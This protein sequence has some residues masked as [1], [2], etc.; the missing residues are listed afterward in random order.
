MGIRV[1]IVSPEAVPFAKT[2]GLA[3]VA[4]SLPKALKR[5]G[6]DV[7][8]AMPLYRQVVEGGFD[9]EATDVEIT[10]N[11]G[12]HKIKVP[13]FVGSVDGITVYFV[14]QDEYFDRRYLYGTPDGDYFD[15]LERFTLFSRGL[16][17]ILSKLR[18]HYDIIHCNDWQTGLIPAYLRSIFK[19]D[20]TFKKTASIF[21][22]HNIA[23][24]GVFPATSFDITGLPKDM[25]KVEG[26]E[27]WN[28]INLLKSGIV[29][30]DLITTVSERYSKEIQTEEFGYGLEGIL[31]KRRA[32]LYGVL[33][34]VDY[35][36]WNPEKDKFIAARYT[37]EDLSGKKI[38]KKGLIAEF[39]LRLSIEKP[40]IA[41]ISR[42]AD[43]K[44]FDILSRGIDRI[45]KMDVGMVVLGTGERRYHQI[46]NDLARKYPG[47]LGVKIAY[48]NALAHKIEAGADIFLMPS[49]YEPCGLNQ[50][51]SLRY[52]TVPVVRATGGLDDTISGY[53]NRSGEGDGF[54]FSEY[55]P[56]AMIK[57]IKEAI[58]LFKDK[59]AWGRVMRNGMSEDF[60]WKKSAERY[61]ALYKKALKTHL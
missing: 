43:Q 28:K 14:K 48:D 27:Y 11:I 13:L 40:I 45:M 8:L 17:G 30:S 56:S 38:C 1:I 60:S 58:T 25:F 20:K 46:F 22:I 52:G 19:S 5:L 2:G 18:I 34:G 15:N 3:D 12:L 39:G 47:K 7:T 16:L 6:C 59:D 26:L 49:K 35:E 57:K 23:Y 53:D 36:Q 50:I 29:F 51:Y 21:T 44:G 4:G 61:I 10:I 24:Q 55:S 42:L 54:K 41:V 33:N 32:C 9:I 37:R 31:Q